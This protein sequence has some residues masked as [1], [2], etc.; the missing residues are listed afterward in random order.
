VRMPKMSFKTG[1]VASVICV[2]LAFIVW[3]LLYDKFGSGAEITRTSVANSAKLRSICG[4]VT[5]FVIVPWSIS[6]EDRERAGQLSMRYWFGCGGSVGTVKSKMH[7]L[8]GE[9]IV[10]SIIV[11]VKSQEHQLAAT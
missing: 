3:P 6:L 2:V 5:T 11:K 4:E 10:D 1:G 8:G 9:W 7:H